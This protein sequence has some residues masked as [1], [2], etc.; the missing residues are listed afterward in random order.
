MIGRRG[1]TLG[2]HR[3]LRRVGDTSLRAIRSSE[4]DRV[5]V[6]LV[7]S[8]SLGRGGIPRSG[9]STLHSRAKLRIEV[10]DGIL[11]AAISDP[12]DAPRNGAI[13]IRPPELNVLGCCEFV[14][15]RATTIIG[16]LAGAFLVAPDER[17]HD[18]TVESNRTL[19]S[20]NR[21]SQETCSSPPGSVNVRLV[22][23]GGG[24]F[25]D[26]TRESCLVGGALTDNRPVIESER[27]TGIPFERSLAFVRGSRDSEGLAD[28]E[29]LGGPGSSHVD[30]GGRLARR[31]RRLRDL[32]LDRRR[33]VGG[34]REREEEC[35]CEEDSSC[36]SC[37]HGFFLPG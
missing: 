26:L 27:E 33:G 20:A 14:V 1:L 12:L 3:V 7:G 8:D 25:V 31:G 4:L 2:Y 35:S 23:V 34:V 30:F 18:F 9:L 15:G 11:D 17:L 6:D 19:V 21:T 13:R 37:V 22:D 32:R 10:L 29:F 28:F 36:G 16:A 5:L 24:N